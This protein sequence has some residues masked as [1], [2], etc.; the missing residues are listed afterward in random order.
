MSSSISTSFV[1]QYEKDAHHVFQ[2][3]GGILRQT[4]RVKT[5]VV[6]SST[7]FQ[8]I[9]KGTAVTKAR[10]GL[11]TPMNQDH[12]AIEC[13]LTDRFAGDF[14]D[15]LDESKIDHDERM[16]IAKGGAWACGRA[17]DDD[18]F[19]AMDGTTNPLSTLTLS[20][21]ANIENSI[22]LISE[23]LNSLDVPN[24]GQ[25]YCAI[26]PRLWA[27][28]EKVDAFR[29]SDYVAANGRPMVEG[30]PIMRFR[31]YANV[32]WV[33][34]TGCPGQ[35]TNSCKAFAWHKTAVGYAIGDD[36]TV[37]I[38]WEGQRVAHFVN[39]MFSGGACLIDDSGVVE[40][41]YDD[42]TNLPTS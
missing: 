25:R 29:S 19:T 18:L 30:A 26:T 15:K 38:D 35:G 8:K 39:H 37:D 33:V 21:V 24:D 9:G 41:P 2:R 28:F 16:A 20:S 32:N 36:L 27:L 4:V 6:G 12:T 17:M 10:H 7:T 1:R 5:G 31:N 40:I 23:K 34:H 13:T 42:T 11:V 3:E 22:L 14:V